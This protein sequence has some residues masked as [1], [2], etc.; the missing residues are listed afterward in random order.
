VNIYH[1]AVLDRAGRVACGPFTRGIGAQN[2]GGVMVYPRPGPV[3]CVDINEV[4]RE[5]EYIK[6]LK[7]DCEG[8]EWPILLSLREW[9]RIGAV[10]GEYHL[11]TTR[12]NYSAETLAALLGRHFPF[13]LVQPVSANEQLGK[14]WAAR[15]KGYFSNAQTR[16][17]R[18]G[19]GNYF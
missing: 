19:F 17:Q 16:R 15:V 4:L 6:L 9:S 5:L 3:E 8:S 1:G 10:C 13:V 14:F 18:K 12:P 11:D 7:L 2:T